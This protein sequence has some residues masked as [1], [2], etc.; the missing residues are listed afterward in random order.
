MC[1]DR[2]LLPL[3]TRLRE[4][5]DETGDYEESVEDAEDDQPH[6]HLILNLQ[7]Q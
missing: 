2:T 6:D 3:D 1:L 5:T 4:H 7:N